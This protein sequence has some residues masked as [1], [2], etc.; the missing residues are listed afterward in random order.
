MTTLEIVVTLIGVLGTL[1]S[2][3]FAVL[4]F[5]RSDRGDHK[6]EGKNE[7]VLISDVGYIKSSIDRIEKSMDKLEENYSALKERVVKVETSLEDHIKNK[8][9]H[10]NYSKGGNK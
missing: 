9:L 2:I 1:S 4:A 8:E 3:F 6:Q 10:K 5:R 7:G